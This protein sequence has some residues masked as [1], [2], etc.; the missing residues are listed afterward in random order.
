MIHSVMR[1]RERDGRSGQNYSPITLHIRC[2]CV[3]VHRA[4]MHNPASLSLSSRS[5]SGLI[6]MVTVMAKV[7]AKV[8]IRLS[9][10]WCKSEVVLYIRGHRPGSQP[11]AGLW[12]ALTCLRSMFL[13]NL[14]DCHSKL[15]Q[16][17]SKILYML[18]I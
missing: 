4:L 9:R 5:N 2:V 8:T 14:I 10:A 17:Q 3:C 16:E 11:S 7:M 12:P 15:P 18:S 1:E 13:E 6:V